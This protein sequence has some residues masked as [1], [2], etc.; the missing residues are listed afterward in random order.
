MVISVLADDR[1]VLDAIEAGARGL[2]VL[3]EHTPVQNVMYFVAAAK[4][5]GPRIL[6]E[7]R[8]EPPGVWRCALRGTLRSRS[9]KTWPN[10]LR[11]PTGMCSESMVTTLMPW[12][13]P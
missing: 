5:R 6:A 13:T 3:T 1:T 4:E 2:V 8:G 11:W 12:I 10:G 7:S 9:A